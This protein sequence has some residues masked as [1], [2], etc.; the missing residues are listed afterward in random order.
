MLLFGCSD[1]ALYLQES[2]RMPAVL[3][4]QIDHSLLDC[5]HNVKILQ[6]RCP[7]I[8]VFLFDLCKVTSEL[9]CVSFW[10]FTC[11]SRILCK[12]G[13]ASGMLVDARVSIL[14]RKVTRY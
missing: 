5:G 10:L 7:S 2:T 8:A 13:Q 4:L 1:A 12:L 6:V 11:V 14:Y 9:K 3:P